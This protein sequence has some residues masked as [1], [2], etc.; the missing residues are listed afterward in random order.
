MILNHQLNLFIYF[1]LFLLKL[2]TKILSLNAVSMVMLLEYDVLYAI[3]NLAPI[4]TSELYKYW[5][6][7]SGKWRN[8]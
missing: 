6:D 3:T 7:N 5:N 2:R 1:W 4:G 8:A